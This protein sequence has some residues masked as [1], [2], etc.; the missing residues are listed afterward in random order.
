MQ[1]V[2][3]RQVAANNCSAATEATLFI[4]LR[5][6]PHHLLNVS[7]ARIFASGG[8]RNHCLAR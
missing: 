2:K 5:E 6:Q 1:S 3:M 8:K 4:Q 7:I